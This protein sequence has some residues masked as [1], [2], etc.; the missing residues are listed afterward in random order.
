MTI[1]RSRISGNGAFGLLIEQETV[2]PDV[3]GSLQL[4]GVNLTGNVLGG[5]FLDNVNVI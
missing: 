5:L 3:L 1:R 2:V 4:F